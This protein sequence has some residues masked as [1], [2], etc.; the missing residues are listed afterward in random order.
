MADSINILV[1]KES[2]DSIL[3]LNDAIT[4]T[5]TK[6]RSL[7]TVIEG[8]KKTL[9]DSATTQE[10]LSKAQKSV[11]DTADQLDAAS[12]KLQASEE[13]LNNF[14][15]EKYA[16][17][18][19]NN[20]ALKDQQK[21]I[22][23]MVQAEKQL[24]GT[25][26][27]AEASTKTLTAERKKLDLETVEGAKRLKEINA[28]LDKNTEIIRTNGDAATKQRMN[29][30]NYASAFAGMPGPIGAASSAVQGFGVTLKAALAANPIILAIAG[31]VAAVAGLFSIFV[32]SSDG[33][34]MLAEKMAQLKAIAT[35]LKDEVIHLIRNF[36][37]LFSERQQENT[38]SL[39]LKMTF[40]GARI[41]ESTKAAK[42]FVDT[43]RDINA[44]RAAHISEEA[45][46][47]NLIQKNIF[48]SKDK[49][50]SDKERIGLLQTALTAS[51]EQAKRE[52]EFAEADYNNEIKKTAVRLMRF[53]V[54]ENLLKQFIQAGATEQ[55]EMKKNE[56]MW[57][58]SWNILGKDGI[59]S[60]E[61]LYAAGIEAD[62]EF[63][64]R[65]K[66]NVSQLS[67]LKEEIRKD[68]EEKIKKTSEQEKKSFTERVKLLE[69]D[70]KVVKETS[71]AEVKSRED[72]EKATAAN[73][74]RFQNEELSALSQKFVSGEIGQEDYEKQKYEITRKWSEKAL[75]EQIDG[76]KAAIARG[77]NLTKE[78]QNQLLADVAK[79]KAEKKKTTDK[80]EQAAIQSQIDNINKIITES[81]LSEGE[82]A[83]LLK[84]SAELQKQLD[85]SA[86]KN[87]LDAIKKIEEAQKTAATVAETAQQNEINALTKQLFAGEINY[88][89]YEKGKADINK[90]YAQKRIQNDLDNIN[91]RLSTEKLTESQIADLKKQAVADQKSLDDLEL[92]NFK[93]KEEKKKEI[94]QATFDLLKE[95]GSA[96]FDASNSRIEEEI[97]GIETKR[98]A[99]IAASDA[100]FE[101]KNKKLT[102]EQIQE[103]K[104]KEAEV[105]INAKYDKL[106]AEEKTKQA[107]NDK[108]AAIFNI[109]IQTAEN[110]VK[111]GLNPVL[112]AFAAAMGAVQ[113][114]AVI[115][116]PIPKYAKGTFGQYNTPETF[117]AGEAGTEWIQK[118]TGEMMAITSP[119]VVTN[120]KGSRVFSNPEI[121][122]L[123]Q[124]MATNTINFDTAELK[125]LRESQDRGFNKLSKSLK[126]QKQYLVQNGK[127]VGFKQ[128]GYTKKYLERM[129]G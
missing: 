28:Q 65:N 4:Q 13:A 29:I 26:E 98:D 112:I 19:R 105:A 60:L 78:Q 66:R 100:T 12:K 95:V 75:Q 30:G 77:S 87:K 31:I 111:A 85:D 56:K 6:Y 54:T 11:K 8:G 43:Q 41:L 63:F 38:V 99:E 17:T 58:E 71:D 62:T 107:K 109:G 5:D 114:A 70:V 37:E 94:I 69:N 15:K 52:K 113:L 106:L 88:E 9:Q 45:E 128:S 79:F 72:A 96:I 53:G 1:P 84:K 59:E 16:Q 115:A 116:K 39:G 36:D 3:K 97:S 27:K 67:T 34:R 81:A 110:I 103:Q 51:E 92:E 108:A 123:N 33:A 42:E 124:M 47:N 49:S 89:E 55:M 7:L 21:E 90:E 14:D 119:T 50:K 73:R 2:I 32:Q 122:A 82:K 25:I 102:E 91:K 127:T 22:L 104:K 57:K 35:T 83:E 101:D 129:I 125:A 121:K 61:K 80:L 20:Q 64:S 118:K 10:N 117:V 76:T 86:V 24:T 93:S 68:N 120:A 23:T 48:L 46:E 126:Q 44:E 18:L 74:E 40:L